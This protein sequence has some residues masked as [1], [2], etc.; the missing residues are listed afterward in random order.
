M[1]IINDSPI[2]VMILADLTTQ[3]YKDA[4]NGNGIYRGVD[5]IKDLESVVS[6]MINNFGYED[7]KYT[8]ECSVINILG[9]VFAFKVNTDEGVVYIP[10]KLQEAMNAMNNNKGDSK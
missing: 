4:F 10:A 9:D 2:D 7:T 6:S 8:I 1:K 5:R 3:D